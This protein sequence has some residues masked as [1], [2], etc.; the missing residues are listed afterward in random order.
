MIATLISVVQIDA[1]TGRITDTINISAGVP[2]DEEP[3]SAWRIEDILIQHSA[4]EGSI[5][6]LDLERHELPWDT[7]RVT[8]PAMP[9]YSKPPLYDPTMV[10][11]KSIRGG[12][13]TQIA[14]RVSVP[15]FRIEWGIPDSNETL[16]S[17]H[18]G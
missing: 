12:V 6:I 17:L 8:G 14:M 11:R 1:F 3:E 18:S 10:Y 5:S 4:G 15:V 9:R 16:S 13:L 7:N 2:A